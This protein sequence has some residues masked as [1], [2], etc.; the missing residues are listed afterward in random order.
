[1]WTRLYY[2]VVTPNTIQT[3][4]RKQ[5]FKWF[6]NEAKSWLFKKQEYQP[7]RWIWR[8]RI[9]SSLP[10][11]RRL[12]Q[13]FWFLLIFLHSTVRERKSLL[14][15]RKYVLIMGKI[16]L[17]TTLHS[18]AII[19]IPYPL[20]SYCDFSLDRKTKQKPF[21]NYPTNRKYTLMQKHLRLDFCIYYPES[22]LHTKLL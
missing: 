11:R 21:P 6:L 5:R 12:G 8:G 14:G 20:T 17:K 9:G 3:T 4:A 7:L 1:M 2:N 13:S 22:D 10:L 18:K 15:M 19:W 16:P